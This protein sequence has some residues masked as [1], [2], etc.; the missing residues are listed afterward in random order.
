MY[1]IKPTKPVSYILQDS[2]GDILK[3]GFYSEEIS[4]SKTGN[5]YLVEKV[6]RK[7]GSK[8]LV[9]WKG[10]DNSYDSWIDAK[11]LV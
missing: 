8:L 2:K 10:Y 11:D 7:K 3:G 1:A 5:V 4:K 6:L 9:R